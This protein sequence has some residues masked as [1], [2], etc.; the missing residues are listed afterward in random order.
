MSKKLVDNLQ[1]WE[2]PITSCNVLAKY[3]KREIIETCDI[4][5]E[6]EGKNLFKIYCLICK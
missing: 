2:R 5:I 6:N 4:L 1:V 3:T